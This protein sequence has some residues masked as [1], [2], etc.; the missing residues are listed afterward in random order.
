MGPG[1]ASGR[2]SLGLPRS[3]SAA[4]VPP[5]QLGFHGADRLEETSVHTE[6]SPS[7]ILVTKAECA[8]F[9]RAFVIFPPGDRARGRERPLSVLWSLPSL[10][11]VIAGSSGRT[12]LCAVFL[13]SPGLGTSPQVAWAPFLPPSYIR[14]SKLL[15]TIESFNLSRFS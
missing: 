11:Q 14:L 5:V 3:P 6:Q 8:S 10:K 4:C 15:E 13:L 9:F 7:L 2:V 1:Y 12:L